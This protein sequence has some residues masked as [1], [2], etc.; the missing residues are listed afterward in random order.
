MSIFKVNLDLSCCPSPTDL[1]WE[2]WGDGEPHDQTSFSHKL[3]DDE[4]YLLSSI[5]FIYHYFLIT[6]QPACLFSVFTLI[7]AGLVQAGWINVLSRFLPCNVGGLLLTP[8]PWVLSSGSF[9]SET[10]KAALRRHSFHKASNKMVS[11]FFRLLPSRTRHSHLHYWCT[12]L[13]HR[14]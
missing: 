3:K 14:F 6:F 10:C 9:R 8:S 12:A 4:P 11:L 2:V 7:L 1:S 13:F 5:P